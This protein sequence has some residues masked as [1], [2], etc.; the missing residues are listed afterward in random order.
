MRFLFI[1]LVF[2]LVLMPR[3][4]FTATCEQNLDKAKEIIRNNI[5]NLKKSQSLISNEKIRWRNIHLSQDNTSVFITNVSDVDYE[6][7][8]TIDTKISNEINMLPIERTIKFSFNRPTEQKT[9]FPMEFMVS[10]GVRII[11][12][13]PYISLG[14]SPVGIEP[15]IPVRFLAG[16]M[17]PMDLTVSCLYRLDFLMFKSS[18][19][20][21]GYGFIG[22]KVIFGMNFKL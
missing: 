2:I 4:S 20:S 1:T 15:I 17:Y 6:V 14:F 3:V 5:T 21:V 12:V 19:L 18:Y 8:I 16:V 22:N 11:P 10:T 9:W 13:Q 7:K